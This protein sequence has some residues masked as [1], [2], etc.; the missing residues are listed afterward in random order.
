MADNNLDAALETISRLLNAD[1]PAI[2]LYRADYATPQTL[3]AMRFWAQGEYNRIQS[4]FASAD[5]V[6][7]L[8]SGALQ[9]VIQ[10]IDGEIGGSGEQG[11]AGVQGPSG[12]AGRG[13]MTFYQT[14]QPTEQDSEPGDVWFVKGYR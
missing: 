3:E 14:G 4:G 11:P 6:V 8:I 13:V 1:S 2:E 9:D 7:R 12:P 5:A 10:A